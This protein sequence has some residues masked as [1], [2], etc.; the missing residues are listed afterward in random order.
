MRTVLLS[1]WRGGTPRR[2]CN[3]LN[4]IGRTPD[5]F[6]KDPQRPK[7]GLVVNWGCSK[8]LGTNIP[9]LNVGSAVAVA[10]NK[11]SCLKRLHEKGIPT[12]EWTLEQAKANDWLKTNSVVAH[13]NL[14]AHSG[15]GLELFKKGSTAARQDI[16]LYTR[17]FPKKVECRVHSILDENGKYKSLYLEKKRVKE[18]RFEEF[19]LQETPQTY[20]RTWDNGWIF[21]REV[22]VDLRACQLAA[23]AMAACGLEYGA[24]DIMF[25]DD[26]YVVGEINT[27]PGLEG[28][29]LGFYVTHLGAMIDRNRK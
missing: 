23:E 4:L 20:I 16:K 18:D 6:M 29:A 3:N 19:G 26:K 7:I 27:A 17:Y 1:P 11:L 10:A 13:F 2:L 8:V 22:T 25:N 14:H 12:L 15:Q 28:K 5:Q 21:A 24:V 9:T